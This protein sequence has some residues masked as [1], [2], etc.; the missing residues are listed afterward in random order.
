ML[1][2]MSCVFIGLMAGCGYGIY[3]NEEQYEDQKAVQ[4]WAA[5]PGL[6]TVALGGWHKRSEYD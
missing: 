5:V 6:C 1:V 2:C 3:E 4:D